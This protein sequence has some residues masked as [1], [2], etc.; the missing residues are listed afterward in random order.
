MKVS[1]SIPEEDVAFL[2]EYARRVGLAS[3]SAA[4]HRAVK[5]LRAHELEDDYAGAWSDW[6]EEAVRWDEVTGD[7]LD[8]ER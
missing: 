1:V 6:A 8:S 2:D 4:L 7:G 5:A 3:R